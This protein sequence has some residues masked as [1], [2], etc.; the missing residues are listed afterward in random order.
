MYLRS[1]L[2]RCNPLRACVYRY[3]TWSPPQA[4]GATDVV[5]GAKANAAFALQN[6]FGSSIRLLVDDFRFDNVVVVAFVVGGIA[7]AA[8]PGK[9]R[10]RRRRRGP[11]EPVRRLGL[12]PGR[13]IHLVDLAHRFDQDLTNALVGGTHPAHS[14]ALGTIEFHNEFHSHLTLAID[15]RGRARLGMG[16]T[17]LDGHPQEIHRGAV[18][19]QAGAGLVENGLHG[20][21]LLVAG[22]GDLRGDL[23][24][25]RRRNELAEHAKG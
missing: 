22:L 2:T 12:R 5:C 9:R 3:G 18:V 15:D 11:S 17:E 6:E 24:H 4:K 21:G 20:L 13:Q 16:L 14:A 8:T 10:R 25:E 1:S 23:S 7:P 19:D